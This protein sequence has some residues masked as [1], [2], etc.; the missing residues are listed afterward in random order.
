MAGLENP[1]WVIVG[2]SVLF[3]THL[4]V[5]PDCLHNS[6][7][8]NSDFEANGQ[9]AYPGESSSDRTKELRKS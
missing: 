2:A 1:A 8:C 9:K 7:E 6:L 5:L 4:S 3:A